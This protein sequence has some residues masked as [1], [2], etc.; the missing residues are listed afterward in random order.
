MPTPDAESRS[1][2]RPPRWEYK[3]L[4]AIQGLGIFTACGSACPH[5]KALLHT[6]S[7]WHLPETSANYSSSQPAIEEQQRVTESLKRIKDI[8]AAG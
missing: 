8:L 1:A 6:L 3:A 7:R 2:N 4:G 5:S